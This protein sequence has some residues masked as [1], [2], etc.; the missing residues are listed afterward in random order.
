MIAASDKQIS[1]VRGLLTRAEE[2]LAAGKTIATNS[3]HISGGRWVCDN[4][5]ERQRNLCKLWLRDH[6]LEG[7]AS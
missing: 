7:G 5:W 3:G 1:Q 2:K 4:G 6:G